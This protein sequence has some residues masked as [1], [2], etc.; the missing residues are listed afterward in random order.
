MM[1]RD[2]TLVRALLFAGMSAAC[3]CAQA[4]IAPI[5][6]DYPA[7]RSVFPPD[8]APPTFLWRDAAALA[9]AWRIDVTFADGSA[10]IRVASK[11]DPMQI[12][13]I[14]PRCV[15]PTNR[16]PALTP[17][18]AAAHTWLPDTTTWAAIAKHSVGGAATVTI[19]GFAPGNARQPV[20][21]G[22][23]TLSTSPDPVWSEN[24]IC[25]NLRWFPTAARWS[26]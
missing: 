25:V 24:W 7:D 6:I 12:G 20:S 18:Q 26:R 11:G 19:S 3:A 5:V 9:S 23:M 13:K 2:A 16:P 4:G 15:A 17:Q 22:R 1:M 8:M 21:V 10:A 14:D